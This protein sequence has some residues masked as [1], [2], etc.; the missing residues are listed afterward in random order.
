MRLD[1]QQADLCFAWQL[2]DFSFF[3][4]CQRDYIRA[5]SQA[6]CAQIFFMCHLI[7][8]KRY[9]YI[10]IG[11]M[12]AISWYNAACNLSETWN[13]RHQKL[14][15]FQT[16][17]TPQSNLLVS[18]MTYRGGESNPEWSD[19]IFG[20]IKNQSTT[21]REKIFKGRGTQIKGSVVL[22]SLIQHLSF[23]PW[24]FL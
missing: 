23:T 8:Q 12:N 19:R 22:D 18:F 6:T 10:Q 15:R 9:M 5:F 14:E 21:K 4:A 16:T 13:A 3:V 1:K 7:D 20:T 11:K 24:T 17:S 2:S